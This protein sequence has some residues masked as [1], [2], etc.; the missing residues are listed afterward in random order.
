METNWLRG[1]IPQFKVGWVTGQEE[2]VNGMGFRGGDVHGVE[3]TWARAY[4]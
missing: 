1:E 3:R 4:P 2:G